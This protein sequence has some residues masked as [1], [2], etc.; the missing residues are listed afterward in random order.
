MKFTS[1]GS[2]TLDGKMDNGF[3]RIRVKDTGAGIALQDQE[4]IWER[5]FK[6]DRGR[7]KN[8]SGTGLGLAIVKELVELHNGKIDV[9]SELNQGT[10]FHI[11]IPAAVNET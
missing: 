6:A 11:W 7:S 2:V 10:T 4:R 5:F 3:V 8:N 1:Q 9:E